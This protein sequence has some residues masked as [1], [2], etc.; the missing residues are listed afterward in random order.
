MTI[1]R[2]LHLVCPGAKRGVVVVFFLAITSSAFAQPR[3]LR[4]DSTYTE[5]GKS[6]DLPT[7]N[8]EGGSSAKN[9]SQ[10]DQRGQ[11]SCKIVAGSLFVSG[12]LLCSWGISSWEVEKYQCC[13]ARNTDNVIKIVAG[14]LLINAGLLYLIE[15]CD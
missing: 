7:L 2:I 10:G 14:V 11:G 15:G 13:P 3:N 8:F 1:P 6:L 12:L 5:L 9:G 4:S